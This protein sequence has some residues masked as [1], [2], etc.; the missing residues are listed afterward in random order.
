[1][2]QKALSIHSMNTQAMLFLASTLEQLGRDPES[3][4]LYEQ[5][6][7]LQPENTLALSNAANLLIAQGRHAEAAEKCIAALNIDRGYADAM[8]NLAIAYQ[9]MNKPD[10]AKEQ[11]AKAMKMDP[12]NSK[13][14]L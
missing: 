12:N 1:M 4:K 7:V 6:N 13:V 5:I 3:L 8:V 11:L 14:Y 2:F 9:G 10:K